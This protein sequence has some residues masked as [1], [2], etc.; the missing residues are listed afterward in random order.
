MAQSIRSEGSSYVNIPASHIGG[1]RF[2]GLLRATTCILNFITTRR[3]FMRTDQN[4]QR[5]MKYQ[6]Y[7][8]KRQIDRCR[9]AKKPNKGRLINMIFGYHA[10]KVMIP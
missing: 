2:C 9:A 8:S 1:G 7:V 4:N 6:R 5:T 10:E 3:V